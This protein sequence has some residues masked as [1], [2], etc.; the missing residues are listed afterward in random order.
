MPA[1][2]LAAKRDRSLL[3]RHPWIFS[4]AIQEVRDDPQSGDAV[5][6]LTSSGEWLARG[7]YSPESAIRARVWTFDRNEQLDAEFC[8]R[9]V[10]DAVEL[11]QRIYGGTLPSAW[12][13]L[14]GEGDGLPGVV[15]DCYGDVVVVQLLTCGAEQRRA[16]LVAALR[17]AVDCSCIY[18]RSDT[19]ARRREGLEPRTGPVWGTPPTGTLEIHEGDIRFGLDIELGHKTGFYLDQRENRQL[20]GTRC[21]DRDVLNCFCYTGGFTLHALAGGARSTLS[22][23]TSQ[24]ALDVAAANVARN[25]FA[26]DRAEFQRADVFRALRTFRDSRKDFDVIVL[27]PPKFADTR[28]QLQ[29][30][31]RGYKDIN[32]LGLKLLRPG[33]EL[34]TFSCSGAMTTELFQKIV[35]DAALDAGREATVLHE[36]R[37]APD[38]VVSTAFPEGRY[39]N[40]LHLLVH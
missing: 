32:L 22:I 5:D 28:G 37:Q 1:L 19:D 16:E 33:G 24:E 23:D 15:A 21:A 25:G 36:L 40:G 8:A 13:I 38:H 11:R 30:A 18:E 3:R 4:G 39:L 35:A 12:R 6:V 7:T 2:V 29:K 9:R 34:F 20:L 10:R 31:S 17:E 26:P 27:D 14:N